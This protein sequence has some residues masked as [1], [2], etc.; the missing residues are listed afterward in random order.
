MKTT[1]LWLLVLLLIFPIAASCATPSLSA[2][3]DEDLLKRFE[4]ELPLDPSART[5]QMV[6]D[7]PDR[8]QEEIVRRGKT[9][10]PAILAFYGPR[11]RLSTG[12]LWVLGQIGDERAFGLLVT[13]YRKNPNM[14][15]AIS[16]GSCLDVAIAAEVLQKTFPDE[17]ALR[18]LLR[19]VFSTAWPKVET[20]PMKD[21]LDTLI[22]DARQIRED[23]QKRSVPQL[24]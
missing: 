4:G 12:I 22:R 6:Y 11:P 18:E 21:I 9:I 3:S 5:E 23:C 13:D 10:I 8:V 16:I 15:S 24:G 17:T 19:E 2:L 7:A 20:L 1:C 14:R